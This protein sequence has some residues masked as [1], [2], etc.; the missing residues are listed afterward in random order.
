MTS[1]R[2]P[3]RRRKGAFSPAERAAMKERARETKKAGGDGEA[4]VLAKLATMPAPDRTLGERIHAIVR[5]HAPALA[6]KLWYGMPAYADADGKV[7]CF[8]QAGSKFGT[9]YA[10]LGF[11]DRARLDEGALWPTA[12]AIATLG[13]ADEARLAALVERAAG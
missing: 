10:T 8:F 6:P 12:F 3:S 11:S 2:K 1:P 4:D 5:A 13:D 9:R 7:V